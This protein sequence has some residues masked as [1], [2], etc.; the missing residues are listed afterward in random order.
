[1]WKNFEY[2]I[3]EEDLGKLDGWWG[4]LKEKERRGL[5]E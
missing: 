3:E 1:M 5:G 2:G 4:T